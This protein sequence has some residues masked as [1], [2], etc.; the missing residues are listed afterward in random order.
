MRIGGQHLSMWIKTMQQADKISNLQNQQETFDPSKFIEP[1]MD[2]TGRSDWKKIVEVSDDI[3]EKV[4]EQTRKNFINGFGMVNEKSESFN[5]LIKKHAQTLPVDERASTMWTL[6]QIK[7]AEAQKLVDIVREN[8]PIW[9]H[10]EPFD[11]NIFD[12]YFS[13][14]GF[15]KRV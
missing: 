6:T 13:S 7:T 3:K 5:E 15:D 9:K 12:E 8:N 14:S 4:I 10:G 11:P 2:I 1:G